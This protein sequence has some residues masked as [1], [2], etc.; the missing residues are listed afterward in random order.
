MSQH[1]PESN[2]KSP[3]PT[4]TPFLGASRRKSWSFSAPGMPSHGVVFWAVTSKLPRE[5]THDVG[6]G[7]FLSSSPE[8]P[9]L[10][11]SVAEV[12]PP[13]SGK[14]A[15]RNRSRVNATFLVC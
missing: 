6:S 14:W 15:G 13:P 12:L 7:E 2:R 1:A 8:R 5:K 11:E 10:S 9:E 3:V 4:R